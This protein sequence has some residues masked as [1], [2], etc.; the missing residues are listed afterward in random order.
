MN[1]KIAE[2]VNVQ[3]GLVIWQFIQRRFRFPPIEAFFPVVRK[4]TYISNGRTKLPDILVR[5]LKLIRE[6]GS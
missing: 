5:V 6:L 3:L 4:S 1:I 2:T